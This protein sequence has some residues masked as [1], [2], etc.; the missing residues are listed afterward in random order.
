MDI[1]ELNIEDDGEQYDIERGMEYG[2]CHC[3]GMTNHDVIGCLE[4]QKG[5][6]PIKCSECGDKYCRERIEE[7][8]LSE[9]EGG[10]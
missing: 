1:L 9:E 6:P 4:C 5:V 7:Q 8:I 10:L 3:H 2:R